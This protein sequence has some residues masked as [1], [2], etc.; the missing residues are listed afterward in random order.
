[1]EFEELAAPQFEKIRQLLLRLLQETG[2]KR[3]D[4]DEIEMVG[5]SSR[6]PMIRRIVQDVFNK[7]PKTT[8]NLDEA[9]ARGAAMQCAILSPAFRVREFSVK[10]SQPYR[11]KIIW[12]GGASESG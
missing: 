3:E 2:V 1:A 11:V 9:V 7:D 12:S 10:D 8:M 6:I 5:G 4:V